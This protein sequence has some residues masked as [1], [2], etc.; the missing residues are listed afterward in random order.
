MFGALMDSVFQIPK[1][2]FAEEM[3]DDAQNFNEMEAARAREFN[4]AQAAYQR[5]WQER[6]SNTAHQRSVAD[7]SKAG[8]NPILAAR[9]GGAV[10]GGAAAASGPAGS[11]GIGSSGPSGTN[12]AQAQLNSAQM[13][14]MGKQ[15]DVAEQQKKLL[16]EQT[17]ETHEGIY[18]KYW[19]A[20]TEASRAKAAVHDIDRARHEAS[21]AGNSAKAYELEGEID[22]TTYG[23][24]MR[25]I[26]RSIRS[27]TGAGSA[28]RNFQ[29]GN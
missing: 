26:D 14:L 25:Y 3:Q 27:I 13:S 7:L 24:I 1:N 9:A 20:T 18:K 28:H 11:S 4:S 12:F 5:D 6:M 21:I 10:T 17:R 22:T 8:L 15:E 23:K 16:L 29:Q 19:E 2:M